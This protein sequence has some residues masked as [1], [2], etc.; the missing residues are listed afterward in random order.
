MANSGWVSTTF[1]RYCP[2]CLADTADIPGG[3]VW[4]GSWRLP[5]IFICSRHTMPAY[6]V[7]G[8]APQAAEPFGRRPYRW[9]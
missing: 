9:N 6:P 3:P 2:D 4:Q 7:D 8:H 1:S 5:H